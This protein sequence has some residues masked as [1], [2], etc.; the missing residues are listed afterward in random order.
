MHFIYYLNGIWAYP[1]IDVLTWPLRIIFYLILL[2]FAAGLYYIGESLDRIIWGE[3]YL[4]FYNKISSHCL[5]Y[6]LKIN[7]TSIL[8]I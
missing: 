3:Y 2:V 6:R 1:V 7:D 5:K 4:F 8:Q